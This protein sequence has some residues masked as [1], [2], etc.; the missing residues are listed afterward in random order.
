MIM[1][2]LVEGRYTENAVEGD[3]NVNSAVS[4]LWGAVSP[5]SST[6]TIQSHAGIV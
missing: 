2:G 6:W 3:S 5:T 4:S 1:D